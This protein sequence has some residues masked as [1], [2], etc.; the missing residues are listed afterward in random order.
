[1]AQTDFYIYYKA[2]KLTTFLKNTVDGH[3]DYLLF[4]NHCKEMTTKMMKGE[5]VSYYVEWLREWFNSISNFG[6]IWDEKKFEWYDK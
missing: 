5:D 6:V 1:M 2:H 4:V 3:P